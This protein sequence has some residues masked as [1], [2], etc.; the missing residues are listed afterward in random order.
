VD[1]K[2]LATLGIETLLTELLQAFNLNRTDVASMADHTSELEAIKF[3]AQFDAY[4]RERSKQEIAS[5]EI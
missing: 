3:V 5:P 2:E 1:A 4:N